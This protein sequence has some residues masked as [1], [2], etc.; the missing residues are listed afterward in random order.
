[1]RIYDTINEELTFIVMFMMSAKQV[2][3]QSRNPLAR[4]DI[5]DA[6]VREFLKVEFG[7]E[8]PDCSPLERK[9]LNLSRQQ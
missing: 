8:L 6:A 5:T 9:L 7:S 2:A 3:G 4:P 1:M